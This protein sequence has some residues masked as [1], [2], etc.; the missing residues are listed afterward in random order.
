MKEH[1]WMV[2][3]GI[4]TGCLG[5]P[6]SGVDRGE[7][8]EWALLGRARQRLTGRSLPWGVGTL[9]GLAGHGPMP[10]TVRCGSQKPAS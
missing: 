6:Q 4:G 5:K 8:W 3:A 10:Q 1:G 9:G 7:A 2:Q